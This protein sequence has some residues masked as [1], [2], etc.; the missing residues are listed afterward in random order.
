[1]IWGK[2]S[3]LD[4]SSH[5]YMRVCPSVGP[6]VRPSV[7]PSVGRSVTLSSKNKG[8]QQFRAKYCHRRYIRPS[9]CIFATLQDGPSVFQSI[10]LSVTHPAISI[11]TSQSQS[12]SRIISCNHITIQSLCHHEDASLALWALFFHCQLLNIISFAYA[13]LFKQEQVPII[14]L[15]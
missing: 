8:N 4:A 10:D 15:T 14:H 11:W 5:L 12:R 3:L 1:M 9:W 2:L 6:S 13:C 7:R